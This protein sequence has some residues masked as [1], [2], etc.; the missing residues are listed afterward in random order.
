M[1][2]PSA[3]DSLLF[4]T[5]ASLRAEPALCSYAEG[6]G[7]AHCDVPVWHTAHQTRLKSFR[8]SSALERRPVWTH[9]VARDRAAASSS[10]EIAKARSRG[11]I[12]AW[13]LPC[14]R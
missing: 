3:G 6:V 5:D 12:A 4:E 9:A 10:G 14:A 13:A 11:A 2:V 8:S 7:L 1:S